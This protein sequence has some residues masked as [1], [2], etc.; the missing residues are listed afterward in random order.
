MFITH[1]YRFLISRRLS[2]FLTTYRPFTSSVSIYAIHFLRSPSCWVAIIFATWLHVSHMQY[3]YMTLL[4]PVPREF[5]T[6]LSVSRNAWHSLDLQQPQTKQMEVKK[7]KKSKGRRTQVKKIASNIKWETP[8]KPN[9][10]SFLGPPLVI[11]A[12]RVSG[13]ALALSTYRPW[14]LSLSGSTL[15]PLGAPHLWIR[16]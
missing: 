16:P 6:S 12:L 1:S 2:S 8:T 4:S 9:Q 3:S 13:S 15:S 11:W 5:T 14:A 10:W 7:D